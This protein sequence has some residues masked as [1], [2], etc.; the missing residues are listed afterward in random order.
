MVRL[1]CKTSLL[2]GVSVITGIIFLR[3]NNSCHSLLTL[4]SNQEGFLNSI[5]KGASTG[6]KLIKLSN[7][8]NCED[9]KYFAITAKFIPDLTPN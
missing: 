1:K 9:L 3:E 8:L 2:P 7:S 4:F 6:Q 5:A